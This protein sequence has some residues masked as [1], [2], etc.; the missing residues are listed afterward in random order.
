[1]NSRDYL[2][3]TSV[4][5]KRIEDGQMRRKQAEGVPPPQPSGVKKWLSID[6]LFRTLVQSHYVEKLKNTKGRGLQRVV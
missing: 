6:T 4:T 5:G 3:N 1:M 2:L